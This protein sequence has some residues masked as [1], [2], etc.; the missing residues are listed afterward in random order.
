MN[1]V[2]KFHAYYIL[3]K[4][5]IFHFQ[6][7]I[8]FKVPLPTYQVYVERSSYWIDIQIPKESSN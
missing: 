3:L 4:K 2:P 5:H 1:I 6:T 7:K 8:A